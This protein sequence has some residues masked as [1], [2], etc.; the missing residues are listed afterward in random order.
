V[1]WEVVGRIDPR[2]VAGRLYQVEYAMEAIGHAGA[3]IGIL[4]TDGVVCDATHP[5]SPTFSFERVCR[6]R[7]AQTPWCAGARGGKEDHLQA[8][9]VR[10]G[11]P[12]SSSLAT[13]RVVSGCI[14]PSMKSSALRF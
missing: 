11:E 3:A 1:V 6:G 14:P 9:R 13:A 8:P 5:P 2:A 7:C 10:Q 4:G 12:L